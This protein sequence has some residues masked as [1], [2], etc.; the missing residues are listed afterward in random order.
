MKNEMVIF[1]KYFKWLAKLRNNF[2]RTD[3]CQQ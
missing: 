3:E 1:K 2:M